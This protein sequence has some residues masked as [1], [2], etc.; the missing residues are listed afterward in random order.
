KGHLADHEI[1]H[2]DESDPRRK[3]LECTNCG[4]SY[5]CR[6]SFRYHMRT[7]NDDYVKCPYKCDQCGKE[8]ITMNGLKYHKTTHLGKFPCLY[9]EY[10][11]SAD[12]SDPSKKKF[13]CE[14]CGKRYSKRSYITDHKRNTRV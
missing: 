2:L 8:F 3:N 14:I 12:D 1:R 11:P 5:L 13:E 10:F 6:S 9:F 7:H 4:K